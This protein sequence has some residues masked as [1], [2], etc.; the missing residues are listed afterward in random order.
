[1][2]TNTRT[3]NHANQHSNPEPCK[4]TLNPAL[5]CW[6]RTPAGCSRPSTP[7]RTTSGSHLCACGCR[8]K[9]GSPYQL[10]V[11]SG[12]YAHT[13]MHLHTLTRTCTYKHMQIHMHVHPVRHTCAHIRT[14]T[15]AH[16]RTCAYTHTHIHA[17][18]HT[19]MHTRAHA[20]AWTRTVARRCERFDAIAHPAH[21]RLNALA[22]CVLLSLPASAPLC[23]LDAILGC[24]TGVVAS[25]T[26][27]AP[28]AAG[29]GA[30]GT[31]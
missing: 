7:R 8:S 11:C 15:R 2:Q 5:G 6:V 17:H 23:W 28:G 13:H 20:R 3:L 31:W 16:T 12:L 4:P 26:P 21:R 27:D 14:R 19:H 22:L 24:I 10:L 9:S 18:T 1:M 30:A 29:S 25:G